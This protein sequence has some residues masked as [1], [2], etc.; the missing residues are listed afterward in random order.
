M[1]VK[2]KLNIFEKKYIWYSGDLGRFLWNFSLILADFLLP[3][4]RRIQTDPDPTQ[5]KNY[6]VWILN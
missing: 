1:S 6:S 3:E 5:W 4:M 2:Q